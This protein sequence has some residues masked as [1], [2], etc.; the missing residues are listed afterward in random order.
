MQSAVPAA[1]TLLLNLYILSV[2]YKAGRTKWWFLFFFN[3]PQM[4]SPRG[5]SLFSFVA[6][7]QRE[8]A[9]PLYCMVRM[10]P[11]A[12]LHVVSSFCI[13][14]RSSG[15]HL[16]PFPAPDSLACACSPAWACDALPSRWDNAAQSA[17]VIPFCSRW[18]KHTQCS[19]L[20]CIWDLFFLLHNWNFQLSF[21]IV[22]CPAQEK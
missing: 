17:A 22:F 14:M 6:S 5:N 12:T 10:G 21:L 2:L 13:S 7:C 8:C 16:I 20:A 1:D 4:P 18:N 3:C 15:V 19:Y 9:K 11:R